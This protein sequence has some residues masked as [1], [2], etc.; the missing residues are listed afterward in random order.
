MAHAQSDNAAAHDKRKP[1]ETLRLHG[2]D[3]L[4]GLASVAVVMLH[5]GVPYMV[6]PLARLVWPARDPN[7]SYLVDGTVWGIECFIMPLFFMLAGFFSAGLLVATGNW[8]F[9][10]HRTK[11]IFYPHLVACAVILPPCFYL[12]VLGWIADGTFVPKFFLYPRLPTDLKADVFG[13]AHIW[14]LQYLYIYCLG[15]CGAS[16][17]RHRLPATGAAAKLWSTHIN[18]RIDRMFLSAWKPLLPAIPCAAIL[19]W[20]PRI[21]LGFYQTILPV[22][23]KL[24]Y[25]SIYFFTGVVVYRHHRTLFLQARYGKRYLAAAAAIFV[26]TLP[27]I[28]EHLSVELA[29]GR[30]ALMAVLLAAFAWLMTFGLFGS[31]LLAKRG[32]NAVTKY[33]AEASY[34]VYIVHL[35]L[36]VTTQIALFPLALPVPVKYFLTTVFAVSMCLLS[37]HV[38]ARYTWIGEALNGTRRSRKARAASRSTVPAAANGPH[39]AGSPASKATFA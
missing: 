35:P 27:M 26:F 25:Y 20:D 3:T 10:T 14:F 30:R 17:L 4:R 19:F 18:W 9:V 1:G 2:L 34:W 31:F 6:F 12:W 36:V 13:T 15:L 24:L 32:Y 38:L 8:T 28:H 23:S 11:R 7:P 29:G 16:W 33:L 39:I 5:A 21:V 22:H 37:Y